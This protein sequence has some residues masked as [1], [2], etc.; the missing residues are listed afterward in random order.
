MK[1][2]LKKWIYIAQFYLLDPD[3][4][5]DLIRNPAFKKKEFK[6]S[7]KCLTRYEYLSGL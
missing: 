3:P 4:A 6:L 5:G 7:E 1:N 2:L